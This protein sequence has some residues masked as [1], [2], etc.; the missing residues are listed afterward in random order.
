MALDAFSNGLAMFILDVLIICLKC[1]LLQ[2][3][4]TLISCI[5]GI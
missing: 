3:V 5:T 4:L 2:G 1:Y